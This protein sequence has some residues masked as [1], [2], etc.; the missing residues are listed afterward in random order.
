[1]VPFVPNLFRDTV[2]LKQAQDLM[3]ADLDTGSSDPM[4]ILRING[5]EQRSRTKF[6]TLNPKWEETFEFRVKNS[7]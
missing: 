2:L 3:V 1:M 4:V 7:G 6:K 5:Q